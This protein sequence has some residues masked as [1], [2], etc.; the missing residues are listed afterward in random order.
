MFIYIDIHIDIICINICILHICI[1]YV[2]LYCIYILLLFSVLNHILTME[3]KMPSSK[4]F[5]EL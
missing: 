2:Y 4:K 1:L 3:Y 5:F